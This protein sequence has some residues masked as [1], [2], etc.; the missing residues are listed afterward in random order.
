MEFDEPKKQDAQQQGNPA[1]AVETPPTPPEPPEPK[2]EQNEPEGDGGTGKKK[3]PFGNAEKE[4]G[5]FNW[6]SFADSLKSDPES[7]GSSGISDPDDDEDFNF[8]DDDPEEQF[9]PPPSGAVEAAKRKV[10]LFETGKAG[11]TGF[12]VSSFTGTRPDPNRYHLKGTLGDSYD[13]YLDYVCTECHEII[14]SVGG[15]IDPRL[16]LGGWAVG[17]VAAAVVNAR[18]DIL[19]HRRGQQG[20]PEKQTKQKAE[21]TTPP[22][23]PEPEGPEPMPEDPNEVVDAQLK[24]DGDMSVEE[25]QTEL[26]QRING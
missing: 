19:A 1:D 10:N 6:K 20:E 23:P 22:P 25:P 7:F 21:T 15:K 4:G 17:S 5:R 3:R 13:Y 9:T 8:E 24:E 14:N 11:L 2:P 12:A 18:S 16:I 26:E